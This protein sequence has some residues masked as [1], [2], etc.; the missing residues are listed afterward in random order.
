[1]NND[2]LV[3]VRETIAEPL[4]FQ[5]A[6][7]R[8]EG[9]DSARKIDWR[10]CRIGGSPGDLGKSSTMIYFLLYS[11]SDDYCE[12]VHGK[13]AMLAISGALC[14]GLNSRFWET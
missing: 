10:G 3:L 9:A 12:I 1:M 11:S 5:L 8:A 7:A 2:V 13:F 6:E 14:S 4:H